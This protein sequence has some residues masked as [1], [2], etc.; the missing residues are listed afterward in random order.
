VLD[1]SK[2]PMAPVHVLRWYDDAWSESV[3][4]PPGVVGR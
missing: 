2:S 4:A 3:I 1:A